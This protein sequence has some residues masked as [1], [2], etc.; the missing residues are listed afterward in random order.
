LPQLI[1]YRCGFELAQQQ[2]NNLAP[3]RIVQVFTEEFAD[4]LRIFFLQVALVDIGRS[5]IFLESA[6]DETIERS[7]ADR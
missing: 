6:M 2:Q 1:R 7:M 3:V 4:N 5:K